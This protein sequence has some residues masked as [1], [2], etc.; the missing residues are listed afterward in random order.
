[1][2]LPPWQGVLVDPRAPYLRLMILGVRTEIDSVLSVVAPLG[3]AA[4]A[5]RPVLVVDLDPT[6]PAY[7]GLRSLAEFVEDGP[8][9]AE[10]SPSG[11]SLSGGR[12]AILRNGGV[13]AEDAIEVIEALAAGWPNLVVRIVGE[14]PAPWPVIPVVPLFPGILAPAAGRGAVWQATAVMDNPPGPGPV[15][16]P[17]TRPARTNLLHMRL[18]PPNRWVSAWRPVWGL[19][20]A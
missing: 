4:A 6:G 8:R 19:A 12:V 1:M 15:L 10:M 14:S 5:S 20:W 7:P 2:G 17:L 13:Q 3:L 11:S 9:R 16:P 18:F